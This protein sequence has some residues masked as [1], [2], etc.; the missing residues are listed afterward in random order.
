MLK[1][2]NSIEVAVFGLCLRFF[3]V[4]ILFQ[5]NDQSAY[6]QESGDTMVYK[7]VEEMPE[8]PEGEDAMEGYIL[9]NLMYP[10]DARVAGTKGTVIIKVIVEKDGS[11]SNIRLVRGILESCNNEALR[12]VKSMPGFK[13]AKQDKK[14]VRCFYT[15][16]IVFPPE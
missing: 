12:I 14:I 9:K 5:F 16:M 4:G 7:L 11:F 6:S 8:Y 15:F 2:G 3:V 13:P 10:E 1:G